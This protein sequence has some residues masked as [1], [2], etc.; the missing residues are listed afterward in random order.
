MHEHLA[1]RL[2]QSL[3]HDQ[4]LG[5]VGKHLEAFRAQ[6]ARSLGEAKHVRLQGIVFAD[7]FA[8]APDEEEALPRL[9]W[10]DAFWLWLDRSAETLAQAWEA[11]G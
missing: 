9:E 1:A 5:G 4:V 10:A 2:Q 7:D 8:T 11:G 3:G 6:D